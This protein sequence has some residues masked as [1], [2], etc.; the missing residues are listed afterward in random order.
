MVLSN[1]KKW[2]LY[3]SKA[4]G[5]LDIPQ[6]QIGRALGMTLAPCQ[7][8]PGWNARAVNGHPR[9]AQEDSA[10]RLGFRLMS[11]PSAGGLVFHQ[12]RSHGCDAR[13]YYPLEDR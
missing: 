10:R 11:P 1:T 13:L 7:R 8:A 3:R 6:R 5:R 9:E 4:S 12:G 2:P